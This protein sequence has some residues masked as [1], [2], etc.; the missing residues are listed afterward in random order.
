M[1]ALR[2]YRVYHDETIQSHS[3]YPHNYGMIRNADRCAE[4]A[5]PTC[6]DIV[7][8][9]LVIDENNI[10]RKIHFDGS[11][12]AIAT[13][14]ASIMT[15]VLTGLT[16]CDAKTIACNL[17]VAFCDAEQRDDVYNFDGFESLA[18]A[19]DIPGRETCTTLAWDALK[20][21]LEEQD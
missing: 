10:I 9:Y 8:V 1:A 11:L 17:G 3:K 16:V 19:H 20:N 18:S 21:A 12:C 14:S 2:P 6:G 5:N 15:E 4:L 13:A 7:T